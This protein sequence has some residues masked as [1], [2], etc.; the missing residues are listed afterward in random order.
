MRLTDFAFAA[1]LVAL[2]AGCGA[3][4]EKA[5]PIN[6]TASLE[7]AAREAG[8]I[9]DAAKAD[10]QG[11]FQRDHEGG[12]DSL[13]VVRQGDAR[14]SFGM[15]IIFGAKESCRGQGT[16]RRAGD[17][18]I[19]NFSGRSGCFAV[20]DF[21]SDRIAMPGVTDRKCAALCTN[22]TLDGVSFPR[23]TTDEAAA[24]VVLDRQGKPLCGE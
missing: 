18:L 5:T 13:C 20:A 14:Y 17:K 15:E 8:I 9:A 10:P 21:E 23:L 12:R 3:A 7:R 4:G 11:L 24:R 22:A 6:D 16:A 2:L 1:L 19:L